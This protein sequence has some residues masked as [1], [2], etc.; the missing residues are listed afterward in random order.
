MFTLLHMLRSGS[1]TNL[2]SR[3]S[4]QRALSGDKRITYD[5]CEF[6]AF[7]PERPIG[8]QI[9]CVMHNGPHDVVGYAP[10]FGR[11]A[12]EAGAHYKP[13]TSKNGARQSD[14]A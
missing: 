1:G 5:Q 4:A 7:D 11:A 3:M 8:R 10:C 13:Q 14:E 2:R 12:G 6:F 9:C